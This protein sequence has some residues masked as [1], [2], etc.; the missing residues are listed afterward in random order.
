MKMRKKVLTAKVHGNQ[1]P[2]L[3]TSHYVHYTGRLQRV[4]MH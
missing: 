2:D 3:G 1:T 4:K